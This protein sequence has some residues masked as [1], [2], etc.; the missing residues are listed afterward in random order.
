[1]GLARLAAVRWTPGATRFGQ[2]VRPAC[3][4]LVTSTPP[5][6]AQTY[7]SD[8]SRFRM[9]EFLV[10]LGAA[11]CLSDHWEGLPCDCTSRD[12]R[13]Q[14]LPRPRG[15]D[16]RQRRHRHRRA[17]RLRQEQRRRCHDVGARRAERQEPARR[18][19]GG[20]HLRRQRRAQADGRRRGA[21][22]ARRCGRPC[23]GN[24]PSP[25]TVGRQWQRR[26][27]T[28]TPSRHGR[29]SRCDRHA[30]VTRATIR[31]SSSATWS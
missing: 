18:S 3:N 4:G 23:S 22:Q 2:G 11:F 24:G 10:Q 5:A 29:R 28:P 26:D 7:R 13:L 12:C 15:V 9:E 17:E 30:A 20:R 31:R 19:H 16:L 25:A 1:M 14:E 27:G 8:P 21:A 6:T